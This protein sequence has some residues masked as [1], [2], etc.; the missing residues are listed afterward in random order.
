MLL[1]TPNRDF[2]HLR[3]RKHDSNVSPRRVQ[4]STPSKPQR[5]AESPMLTPSPLRYPS[6]FSQDL[7]DQEDDVF[8]SPVYPSTARAQSSARVSTGAHG[9]RPIEPQVDEGSVFMAPSHSTASSK[10]ATSSIKPMRTPYRLSHLPPHTSKQPP[11]GALALEPPTTAGSKRKSASASTTSPLRNHSLTPLNLTSAKPGGF[12]C[13]APLPAPKFSGRKPLTE[14]EAD[15]HMSRHAKE[16]KKLRL[17]GLSDDSGC[18]MKEEDEGH[19]LFLAPNRGA[20]ADDEA[21]AVSPDGHVTKRARS[22]AIPGGTRAPL[23]QIGN[24]TGRFKVP[25][26]RSSSM[27]RRSHGR[28]SSASSGEGPPPSSAARR[29]TMALPPRKLERVESATLFFGPAIPQPK[30]SNPQ[31]ENVLSSNS[32]IASHRRS[33]TGPALDNWTKARSRS[34]SPRSSPQSVPHEFSSGGSEFDDDEEM[35][36]NGPAIQPFA[37]SVTQ[38]TPPPKLVTKFKPRDSGIGLSDDDSFNFGPPRTSGSYMNAIPR[39]SNSAST[40]NSDS[41]DAL[42]TPGVGPGAGSGWPEAH[43]VVTGTEEHEGASGG[44]DVD[45]F[46]QRTLAGASK[47]G[48]DGPKKAPGTPVK[49]LRQFNGS[50]PWRSAVAN[51]VGFSFDTESKGKNKKTTTNKPRKSMP[52]AFPPPRLDS[53]SEDD[54]ESPSKRG[55][56]SGVGMGR[57]SAIP[58]TRWL[59][60][61]SSSGLFNSGSELGTPTRKSDLQLPTR[62]PLF[63]TF[64]RS[65]C[66]TSS[67]GSQSSMTSMASPTLRFPTPFGILRP[68]SRSSV[69]SRQPSGEMNSYEQPGRFDRDFEELAEVGSGNFGKVIKV[70]SKFSFSNSVFAVKKSKPYEGTKHRQRLREEVDIHEHLSQALAMAGQ[71][72]HP[73][74]VA[75]IDSWEEEGTLYLRT[76]FCEGGNFAHFLREYGRHYPRL[77]EGRVWKVL[78]EISNGLAFIHACGVIHLDLKP[79]NILITGEGRFKITDFG[80]ATEWPRPPEKS[81]GFEREGDKLYLAPEIL[82]GAYGKPCDIFSLGITMLE[83]AANIILP[84]Q[85]E[86]WQRLRQEDFE[87]VEWTGSRE[88]LHIIG[89]MMCTDPDERIDVEALVAH[90]IVSRAR[91][92]MEDALARAVQGKEPFFASSPLAGAPPGFLVELLADTMDDA[93]DLSF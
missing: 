12:E 62:S 42:I 65:P 63:S 6:L 79:E 9:T 39:A 8:Q 21:K 82:R 51:K 75:Y 34:P 50:R 90:P 61:R 48:S 86:S 23:V 67:S 84:D 77:D 89:R 29:R 64:R 10:K 32:G 30:K 59:T 68:S 73:N 47:S 2:V 18:E 19:A 60:R 15:A 66:R 46:I 36:F 13:L 69:R 4:Y 17:E 58:R 44:P 33:Q 3:G 1:S 54:Q 41:D 53:D 43:I 88:L 85:G 40:I 37:F 81:V 52:A 28:M 70:R 76:E 49:K 45:A 27:R 72:A 56:Y 7:A 25:A 38:N 57:P 20:D 93:M 11:A 92:A 83:T 5:R 80:M 87:Q 71:T 91:Q 22:K 31:S 26:S 78:A 55:K 16:L 14:Y 24:E 74:I 35:F